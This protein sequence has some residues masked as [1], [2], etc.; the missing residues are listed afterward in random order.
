[1][2]NYAALSLETHLFFSRIMKEHAL[3]LEAGFPC[4]DEAWI[5]KADWFRK[6]FENLLRET[7]K[8][9]N[10]RT[11]KSILNSHELVTDRKSVV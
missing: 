9:S 11:Q 4:K 8:I 1:M 3:F 7:V 2:E 5:K 6:E 10:G